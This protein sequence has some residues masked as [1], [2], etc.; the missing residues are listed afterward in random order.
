M[1]RWS[2]LC[3]RA[4]VTHDATRTYTRVHHTSPGLIVTISNVM[5]HTHTHAQRSTPWDD[6]RPA[7]LRSGRVSYATHT[8]CTT[9]SVQRPGT[10]VTRQK[11]SREQSCANVCQRPRD[12][13]TRADGMTRTHRERGRDSRAARR[14]LM[15]LLQIPHGWVWDRREDQGAITMK[16]SS[17]PSHLQAAT[18]R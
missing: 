7:T 6:F 9:R 16:E 17:P 2:R 12:A 18:R 3:S 10:R 4:Y 5:R 11:S 8:R 13:R 15:L 1:R 14:P